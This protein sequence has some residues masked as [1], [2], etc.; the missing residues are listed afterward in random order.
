VLAEV[1]LLAGA[2]AIAAASAEPFAA[3]PRDLIAVLGAMA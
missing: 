2:L 1:L 3:A